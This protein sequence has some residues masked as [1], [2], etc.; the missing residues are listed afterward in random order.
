[1]LKKIIVFSFVLAF[2][3][4]VWFIPFIY[5]TES[6]DAI[7]VCSFGEYE[8]NRFCIYGAPMTF[9]SY[10]QHS[11][12]EIAVNWENFILGIVI[13]TVYFSF[14]LSFLL[15]IFFKWQQKEIRRKRIRVVI[16]AVCIIFLIALLFVIP[17][18]FGMTIL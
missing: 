4:G 5:V 17:P 13:I 7:M 2:F 18:M 12:G 16:A 6:N 3:L 10:L 11:H 9:I 1:M 14:L 8:Y 15:Y